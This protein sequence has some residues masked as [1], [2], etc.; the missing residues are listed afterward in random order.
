MDVDKGTGNIVYG[1]YTNSFVITGYLYTRG[2]VASFR[3]SD[4]GY[5]WARS[6]YS[7]NYSTEK[8]IYVK[9]NTSGSRLL[10]I[11]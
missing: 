10:I 5:N 6:Y 8:V 3:S 7:N 2:Y 1:G 4:G 11:L 9:F